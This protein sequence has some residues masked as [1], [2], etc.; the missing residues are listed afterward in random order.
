MR[1]KENISKCNAKEKEQ[2]QK[3]RFEI[4]DRIRAKRTEKSMVQQQMADAMGMSR[5]NYAKLE[6]GSSELRAEQ[7]IK[8]SQILG[9]SC[10]FILKGEEKSKDSSLDMKTWGDVI[11]ALGI[12]TSEVKGTH[13]VVSKVVD[14]VFQDMLDCSGFRV[15]EEGETPERTETSFAVE[16]PQ[17]T[18][19]NRRKG[20]SFP[21]DSLWKSWAS[22]LNLYTE[23]Q[24]D[25]EMYMLWIEK[26]AS[27]YSCCYLP[28]CLPSA[29][30]L[31][32]EIIV[33]E[34]DLPF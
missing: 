19:P 8:I 6:N 11:H 17:N 29:P 23:G 25:K 12:L 34:E 33:E 2:S 7:C 16:F 22:L 1:E 5:A 13:I 31:K 4:G 27:E 9:L 3:L 10:E 30:V 14:Y 18:D 21:L 28:G 24:I 32:G 20:S 26:K 15:A